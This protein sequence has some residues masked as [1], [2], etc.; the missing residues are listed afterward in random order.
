MIYSLFSR[1]DGNDDLD[2]PLST[3]PADQ[4]LWILRTNILGYA[5]RSAAPNYPA[6]RQRAEA[7][8]I[9]EAE[10][11]LEQLEAKQRVKEPS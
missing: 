6:L 4:A 1:S 11:R 7:E 8:S 5:P 3:N 2:R 9:A 10:K